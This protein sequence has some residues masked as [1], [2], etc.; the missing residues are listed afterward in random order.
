MTIYLDSAPKID[1]KRSYMSLEGV[2]TLFYMEEGTMEENH[3][4]FI[5][6]R[7]IWTDVHGRVDLLCGMRFTLKIL[8][9]GGVRYPHT[10][11]YT[12]TLGTVNI[13]STPMRYTFQRCLVSIWKTLIMSPYSRGSYW[14]VS[15]NLPKSTL[16]CLLINTMDVRNKLSLVK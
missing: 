14:K 4:Y 13:W 1:L 16:E 11:T 9:T 3:A 5:C 7:T 15:T 10:Y 6:R 12:Y 8:S 2:W